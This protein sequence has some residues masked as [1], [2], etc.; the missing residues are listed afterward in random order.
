M[1]CAKKDMTA[2]GWAKGCAQCCCAFFGAP[3]LVGSAG[4]GSVTSSSHSSDS[5]HYPVSPSSPYIRPLGTA[6]YLTLSCR[7]LPSSR[8]SI[9]L[10]GFRLLS[11]PSLIPPAFHICVSAL[12]PTCHLEFVTWHRACASRCTSR[13]NLELTLGTSLT[14]AGST[15]FSITTDVQ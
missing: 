15:S 6:N 10:F 5:T 3:W 13:T 9:R 1:S 2:P 7:S 12:A 4:V 11:P 8:T 14:W